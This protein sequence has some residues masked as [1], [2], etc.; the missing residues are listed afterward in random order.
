MNSEWY[1]RVITR[2]CCSSPVKWGKKTSA[3]DPVASDGNSDTPQL[4][5]TLDSSLLSSHIQGGVVQCSTVQCNAVHCSV[6][7]CSSVKLNAVQCCVVSPIVWVCSQARSSV[8][9][10]VSSGCQRQ[11]GQRQETEWW[12]VP[13]ASRLTS[14]NWHCNHPA[15]LNEIVRLPKQPLTNLFDI[16]LELKFSL[17]Y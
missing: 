17:L 13:L 7:Q 12:R 14:K 15:P 16:F 11:G 6:M 3:W 8:S 9:V 1:F 5:T 2:E 4:D 10:V